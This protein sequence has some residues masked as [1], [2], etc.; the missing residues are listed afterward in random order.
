MHKG[1]DWLAGYL[2]RDRFVVQGLDPSRVLIAVAEPALRTQIYARLLDHDVFSDTAT[3]GAHALALLEARPYAVVLLDIDLQAASAE[4]L[5]EQIGRLPRGR[6]PVVLVLGST[7][8][9]RSLDVDVVQVILRKPVNL[10]HLAEIVGSCIR[11]ASVSRPA[12]GPEAMRTREEP[13]A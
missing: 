7:G 2:Y 8:A 3:D 1:P 4:R 10:A 13:A 12:A 11:A 9:A 5:V 6:R